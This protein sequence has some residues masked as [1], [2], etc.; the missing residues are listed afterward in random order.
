MVTLTFLEFD[1]AEKI[2]RERWMRGEKRGKWRLM[3]KGLRKA[4]FPHPRAAKCPAPTWQG[5]QTPELQP[6]SHA[7]IVKISFDSGMLRPRTFP[8]P[9]H[10]ELLSPMAKSIASPETSTGPTTPSAK[11]RHNPTGTPIF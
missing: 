9:Y 2:K 11:E 3:A 7:Q 1:R 4:S 10:M 8:L 5:M 6:H